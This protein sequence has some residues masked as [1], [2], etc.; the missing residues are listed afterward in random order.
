MGVLS[1]L[2]S[3]ASA[4]LK[5][6]LGILTGLTFLEVT[7]RV[8]PALLLRGMALPAPVDPPIMTQVYD[9]HSSEADLFFWVPDLIRPIAPEDD[10]IEAHVVFETDEFGFPNAAPLPPEVDVVVLGRSYSVG[11]QSSEP[12]PR[13][14]SR[15]TGY[16]VLNLSQGA[17]GIDLKREYLERYG[18]QRHPRWVIVEVLPSM[19]IMGYTS[20]PPT[21]IQGLVVPAVQELAR[22]S[23]VVRTMTDVEPIFPMDV[24]IPG[25]KVQLTFFT[26]YLAGLTADRSSIMASRQWAAYTRDLQELALET[27]ENGACLVLLYAPTTA[28]IYFPLAVDPRQLQ[29]AL[30]GVTGWRLSDQGWLVGDPRLQVDVGGMRANA[31]T[32]RDIVSAYAA[33]EHWLFVDPSAAMTAAALEGES[34]FMSIDTHWSD[35]GQQLVAQAIATALQ[36]TDC[37]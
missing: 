4:G 10:K 3:L 17:S 37:P 1:R 8:N 21:L 12:W 29:P 20:I 11:A 31:T 9:V 19:D 25:R 34:P 14:L 32:A 27:R 15:L 28:D 13:V 24:D 30:V 6:C 22:R 26:Y 18:L 35:L 7:L 2:K 36:A 23:V 33:K 16:S 5:L